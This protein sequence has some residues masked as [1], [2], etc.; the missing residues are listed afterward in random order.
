MTLHKLS[1]LERQILYVL[2]MDGR[3]SVRDIAEKLG[4]RAHVVQHAIQKFRSNGAITR[5]VA[6]NLFRLGYI[7]HH[8]FL[9]LSGDAQSRRAEIAQYLCESPYTVAV[10][11]VG[12]DYDFL[13]SIISRSP[14]ELARFNQGIATNFGGFI[15]SR[16]IAAPVRHAVFGHK[17]LT[18]NKKLYSECLY[19]VG[20]EP[21]DAPLVLDDTDHRILQAIT[22]PGASTSIS[23]ARTLGLPVSTIDYR[24]KRLETNDIIC[25]DMHEVRGGLLGL[26][27]YLVSV[28]FK[29]VSQEMHEK[30]YQFAKYH[31]NVPNITV[32][33]GPWD[34]MLG[35]AVGP[36]ADFHQL[37][38]DIRNEFGAHLSSVKSFPMLRAHKVKDYPLEI[39][40][41]ARQLKLVNG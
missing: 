27:N 21:S 32:E 2:E 13:L 10:L 20:G 37:L 29:G 22:S 40:Q 6:V 26:T 30:F 34:Y 35:V 28:A 39:A 38:T 14:G 7:P 23:L 8:I 41:K 16:E 1:D 17:T 19:D 5:R 25:G 24:I 15:A 9:R 3:A 36:A 12:G 4:C 18:D 31:P 33:V 11:E